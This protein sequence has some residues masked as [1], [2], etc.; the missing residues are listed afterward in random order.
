MKIVFFSL[1]LILSILI[2]PAFCSAA[3]DSLPFTLNL[4]PGA[5]IAGKDQVVVGLRTS[6]WGENKSMFGLDFGLIANITSDTFA[7]TAFSGIFNTTGKAAYVFLLQ[8]AGV[9]NIN[10]GKVVVAG[11]Q[12]AGAVNSIAGDGKII[13]AQMAVFANLADKTDIYGLQL[14]LYNT[15]RKVV[16]FQIGLLNYAA[17]LRGIQIGLLNFNTRSVPFYVFPV[18]NIGF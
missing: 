4:V 14:G 10:K 16:G 15:A 8:G 7:G 13:G 11:L 2:A 6:A 17:D 9:A 3:D 5:Q 18:F 1:S 12:L